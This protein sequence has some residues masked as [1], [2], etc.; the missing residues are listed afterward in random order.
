VVGG[1][2]G[3]NGKKIVSALGRSRVDL[4]ETADALTAFF[5]G[6]DEDAREVGALVL[7]DVADCLRAVRS[8]ITKGGR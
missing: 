6:G 5:H 7:A 2:S 4:R 8:F 3:G 1:R